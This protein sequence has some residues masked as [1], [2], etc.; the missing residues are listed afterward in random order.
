MTVTASNPSSS[1]APFSFKPAHNQSVPQFQPHPHPNPTP[2]QLR[3]MSTPR[4]DSPRLDSDRY[5]LINLEET[6]EHDLDAILGELCALESNLGRDKSPEPTHL[7]SQLFSLQ[8]SQVSVPVTPVTADS[9]ADPPPPPAPLQLEELLASEPQYITAES[10]RKN[11]MT[12]KRTESPDNDSAFCENGSSNS[13]SDCDQRPFGAKDFGIGKCDSVE[14]VE[15][16]GEAAAKA[17]SEK[18]R[19]AIEKIREA[20]IK[21]IFIKVFAEDGSTKSLLINERM[22]VG[23]VCKMLAEKNH[24]T[25]DASW[26]LVELLP[27]LHMERAFE[28]HESLVENLL[29]WKADSKNT[30]WFIKRPEVYDLFVR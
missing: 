17:K 25:R 19:L 28:D 27:D 2:V 1:P 8:G 7:P 9:P 20:S 5:S 26:G 18:I 24:V 29:M 6:L 23:Q 3:R 16:I 4:T 22:T 10:V 13:S 30:L 12:A 21:K 11:K 14:Q 15:S